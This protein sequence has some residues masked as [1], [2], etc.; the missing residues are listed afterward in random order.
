MKWYYDEEH[1]IKAHQYWRKNRKSLE[2]D[3]VCGCFYCIR[4]FSPN[5]IDEWWDEDESTAECPY[6]GIDSVIG[7]SSGFPI[8]KMFLKEMH[9]KYF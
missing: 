3:K 9:K 7:E 4:I 1:L 6:C 5:E 2:N 8:T